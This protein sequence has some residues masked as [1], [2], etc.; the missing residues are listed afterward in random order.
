MREVYNQGQAMLHALTVDRQKGGNP[1]ACHEFSPLS[2]QT[3]RSGIPNHGC[4][5][6]RSSD[7]IE[8]ARMPRLITRFAALVLVAMAVSQAHAQAPETAPGRYM[9]SPADN[10]FVRL[11]R[12]TGEMAFC[13]RRDG[14]WACEPMDPPGA[15]PQSD[16][17]SAVDSELQDLR[18]E[19]RRLRDEIARLD[20]QMGLGNAPPPRARG[21][22]PGL[23]LPSEEEVDRAIGY[24]GKILKKLK[25]QI[26][27]LKDEPK[28]ATP[29]EPPA[30]EKRL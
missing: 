17:P 29:S 23:N 3:E 1:S 9:M 26:E 8:E 16:D 20:N 5:A 13:Q 14:R 18:R 24:F 11:D 22:V 25:E 15:A 27:E 21:P 2:P 4:F 30:E 10:G 12:R 28:A 7:F 6:I 19:N